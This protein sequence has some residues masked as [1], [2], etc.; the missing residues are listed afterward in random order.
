MFF[1][2]P[3]VAEGQASPVARQSPRAA[4]LPLLPVPRAS[5][6]SEP[7]GDVAPDL[8]TIGVD[9]V[10]QAMAAFTSSL[11]ALGSRTNAL[12][13]Q[14]AAG[15][16]LDRAARATAAAFGG[17]LPG[18]APYA[19]RA[20]SLGSPWQI[21]TPAFPFAPQ[22]P[23]MT[24]WPEDPWVA[25]AQSIDFWAKLWIPAAAQRSAHP[26]LAASPASIGTLP[27]VSVWGQ[28]TYI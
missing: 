7:R 17:G 13:A 22:A 11:T 10:R 4:A 15:L 6:P 14:V 2:F 21:P 9:L 18:I 12:F 28:Q 27:W 25:F 26:S 24:L 20:V 16:A 1:F 5:R 3:F 23:F 19:P 8:P